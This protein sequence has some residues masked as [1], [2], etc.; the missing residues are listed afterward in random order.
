MIRSKVRG[1]GSNERN[2]VGDTIRHMLGASGKET[3]ARSDACSDRAAS[4]KVWR[5]RSAE[6]VSVQIRVVGRNRY[7]SGFVEC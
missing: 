6:G 3:L 4:C 7:P 1:R 5:E 2:V